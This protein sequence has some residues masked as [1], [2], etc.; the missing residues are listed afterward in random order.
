M[1][2]FRLHPRL[3]PLFPVVPRPVW[4]ANGTTQSNTLAVHHL[5]LLNWLDKTTTRRFQGCISRA[6]PRCPA[7][8]RA[9]VMYAK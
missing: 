3:V 9:T 8:S 7:L 4:H 5:E 2:E 1:L 6:V